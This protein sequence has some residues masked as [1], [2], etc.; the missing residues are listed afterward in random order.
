MSTLDFNLDIYEKIVEDEEA[1]KKDRRK[2]YFLFA[3]AFVF[4]AI[5]TAIQYFLVLQR[6]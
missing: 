6:S 3:Q 1:R 5:L 4:G 2:A